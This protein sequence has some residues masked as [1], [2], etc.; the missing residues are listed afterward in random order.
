MTDGIANDRLEKLQAL[1]AAGQDPF[2]A[3]VSRGQPIAELL[4]DF[5]A[6]LDTLTDWNAVTVHDLFHEFVT[7][8]GVGLGKVMAPLRL[9]L[10]GVTG[11]PA[12]FDIAEAIGRPETLRR[13]QHAIAQLGVPA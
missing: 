7:A 11:G 12:V 5:A 10:T 4:T 9:V 3:R 2:P 8:R 13:I 1:R 6:A